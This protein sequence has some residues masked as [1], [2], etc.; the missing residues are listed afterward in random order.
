M[1]KKF[2][3]QV[4]LE[5]S[6]IGGEHMFGLINI[7][8]IPYKKFE[9]LFKSQI[10]NERFL[11]DDSIG[12]VIDRDVYERHNEYLDKEVPF[13]FDFD[14][15]NYTVG[16]SSVKVEDYKKDYYEELPPFFD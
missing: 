1:E 12:Y 10:K 7:S 6:L 8:H 9:E 3:Y 14:I 2:Y 4:D 11:F 13:T 5:V 15:F 16:I